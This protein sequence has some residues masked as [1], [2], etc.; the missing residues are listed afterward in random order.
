[1]IGQK[2]R[3]AEKTREPVAPMLQSHVRIR[4]ARYSRN[5]F[6]LKN[7]ARQISCYMAIKLR[8]HAAKEP[9]PGE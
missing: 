7:R 6:A 4:D 3:S 5:R 1:M 8:L 9:R 2:T